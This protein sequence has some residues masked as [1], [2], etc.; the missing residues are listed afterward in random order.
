MSIKNIY[1]ALWYQFMNGELSAV[2][3]STNQLDLYK[4]H[5]KSILNKDSLYHT[6]NK[7]IFKIMVAPIMCYKY[8]SMNKSIEIINGT[9][10]LINGSFYALNQYPFD[11]N[12]ILKEVLIYL[13]DE[14]HNKWRELSNTNTQV[15]LLDSQFPPFFYEE[16]VS[17]NPVLPDIYYEEG[18]M[19]A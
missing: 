10:N 15:K 12:S 14:D 6:Y 18:I 11:N 4:L 5:E 7:N 19:N 1:Y 13:S 16:L 2:A 17:L 8:N 3:I 9:E